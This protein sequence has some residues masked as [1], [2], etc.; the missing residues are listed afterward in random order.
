M[1]QPRGA[2]DDI[3]AIAWTTL[4][5]SAI[6]PAVDGP[7]AQKP[8]HQV[9][10]AGPVDDPVATVPLMSMHTGHQHLLFGMFDVNLSL[11]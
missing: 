1:G 4:S 3:D 6:E 8:D 7:P 5:R 9:V 10:Q 2:A 11:M